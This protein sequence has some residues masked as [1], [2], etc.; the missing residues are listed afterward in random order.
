MMYKRS[1]T[2]QA[3]VRDHFSLSP[4]EF[5]ELSTHPIIT[6]VHLEYQT[7]ERRAINSK[8]GFEPR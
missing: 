6:T 4:H 8:E 2:L 3:T 5:F 1:P 7:T